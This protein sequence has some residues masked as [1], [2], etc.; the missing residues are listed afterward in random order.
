MAGIRRPQVPEGAG[1]RYDGQHEGGL[2]DGAP[3]FEW[4]F[5]VE[6]STSRFTD[7]LFHV[8]T[9]ASTDPLTTGLSEFL[10]ASAP[11]PHAHSRGWFST[12]DAAGR[13]IESYGLYGETRRYEYD[14]ATGRLVRVVRVG[15]STQTDETL[16][17]FSWDTNGNPTGRMSALGG[18]GSLVI[19][20]LDIEVD[21]QDRLLRYGDR[22]YYY[23]DAGRVS[24]ISVG[25][26]TTSLSYDDFGNLR[27]V[28]SS[29]IG[30]YSEDIRYDVD[31]V[32][33]RVARHV[34]GA[35]NASRYWLYEDA[36]NPVA[37][38]DAQHRLESVFLYGPRAHSPSVIVTFDVTTGA[39]DRVFRALHDM[40]GSIAALVDAES[41]ELVQETEYSAFGEVVSHGGA[42]EGTY[43]PFGFAGGLYDPSTRLTRFGARD[44]DPYAGRWLARDPILWDGGLWNLY[45][46]VGGEPINWV[47]PSGL[48][49]ECEDKQERYGPDGEP[50]PSEM[51]C[52]VPE[53]D[54]CMQ[55]ECELW[56]NQK[57]VECAAAF[58]AN[59][60]ACA[61]Q[62]E[63]H[64]RRCRLNCSETCDPPLF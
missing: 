36:L 10:T 29:D 47:D 14:D 41:G 46:Y 48:A 39:R 12:A 32:G 55:V 59:A 11:A 1:L 35:P 26:S 38:L 28:V 22:D 9:E 63:I 17:S 44:Y 16:E 20:A 8:R 49:P 64:T 30:A 3:D 24:D 40:R 7:T 53:Y 51:Q 37:Q 33:R 57:V 62:R 58:G 19:D 54:R 56:A 4:L 15:D 45:D 60:S 5:H 27:Q 2:T 18:G 34:D 52:T 43:H 23:D 6:R 61:A 31:A 50:Y 42:A 13:V 25:T 21:E